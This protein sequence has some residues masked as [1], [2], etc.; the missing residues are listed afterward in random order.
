MP[1]IKPTQG[2]AHPLFLKNPRVGGG[3]P[4]AP[5]DGSQIFTLSTR[6]SCY[7]CVSVIEWN[8]GDDIVQKIEK[9]DYK[10]IYDVVK[11]I[12]LWERQEEDLR[13][14]IRFWQSVSSRSWSMDCNMKNIDTCKKDLEVAIAKREALEK[15]FQDIVKGV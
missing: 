9:L 11:Y 5:K 10:K 13:E 4:R 7:C 3:L 1:Y 12:L 6:A 14:S 8:K 15:E 2:A